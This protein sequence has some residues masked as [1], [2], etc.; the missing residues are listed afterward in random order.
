MVRYDE[1]VQ[2]GICCALK[3]IWSLGSAAAP[4]YLS[5]GTWKRTYQHFVPQLH[6]EEKTQ[7]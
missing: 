5:I 7:I 1:A 6:G 3:N 2:S 4:S